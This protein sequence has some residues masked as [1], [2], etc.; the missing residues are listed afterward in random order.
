MHVLYEDNHLLVVDKPTGIATMGT[1]AGPTV[2]SWAAEYLKRKYNKPGNVFV[3][4]VSRLDT[5]TSGVLVLA[6]TSKA[7]SRLSAQFRDT[8]PKKTYLAVLEGHLEGGQ[9]TW[10]DWV[11]KD[12]AAHR[13]RCVAPES[14]DSQRAELNLRVIRSWSNRTLVSIQ[15]LTGRK[16]QIRVQASSRGHAVWGDRKYAANTQMPQ[17]IALH[18][19]RLEITHPTRREPLQFHSDPP[20]AWSRLGVT[21]ADLLP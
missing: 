17:G 15:L 18:S 12:D 4:I 10:I 11:R 19:H 9:Q 5:F 7:A 13:M 2:Y 6:R 1:D 20:E 3:G 8:S 21:A 14:A 16:H